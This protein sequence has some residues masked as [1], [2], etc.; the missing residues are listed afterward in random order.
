MSEPT[1]AAPSTDQARCPSRHVDEAYVDGESGP[2][3]ELTYWLVDHRVAITGCDTGSVTPYRP[4]SPTSASSCPK[5][6]SGAQSVEVREN[7]RHPEFAEHRASEFMFVVSHAKVRGAAG[8]LVAPSA[9][10]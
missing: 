9:I 5:I 6:P 2:G 7:H 10:V 3:R 4:S 1:A 8:A